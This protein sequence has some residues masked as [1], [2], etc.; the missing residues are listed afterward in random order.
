[1]ESDLAGDGDGGRISGRGIRRGV[2][3]RA[4]V[5]QANRHLHLDAI[6]AGLLKA[7]G[8]REQIRK[9]NGLRGEITIGRAEQRMSMNW[10]GRAAEPTGLI[11]NAR[12]LKNRHRGVLDSSAVAPCPHGSR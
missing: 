8:L 1:M 9:R 11:E 7:E 3:A 10:S 6:V 5:V 12:E 2:A 4:L